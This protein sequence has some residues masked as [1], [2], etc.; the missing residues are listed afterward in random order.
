MDT[1]SSRPT[2]AKRADDR[3]K[4]DCT[5]ICKQ[6]CN[7]GNTAHIFPTLMIAKSQIAIEPMTHIV[8]VEHIVVHATTSKPVGK[9]MRNC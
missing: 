6:T 2:V 9:S 4:S 7:F 3:D 5:G 8:G 1:S